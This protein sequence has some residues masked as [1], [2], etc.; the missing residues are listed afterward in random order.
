MGAA[1]ESIV[2]APFAIPETP[3]PAIT[4]PIINI[5]EDCAAPHMTEPNS[6]NAR[7][8]RNVY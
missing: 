3:I 2:R 4:R 1:A 8:P 5:N 6:K 7:K